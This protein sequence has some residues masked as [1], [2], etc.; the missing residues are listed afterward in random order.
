LGEWS[1]PTSAWIPGLI[2]RNRL[3]FTL[4]Q[5]L[6]LPQSYWITATVWREDDIVAVSHTDRQQ[7]DEDTVVLTDLPVTAVGASPTPPT[8]TDI[9]FPADGIILAGYD[10]PASAS[11]GDVVEAHFWWQTTARPSGDY[12]QF[13]HLIDRA[14][15]AQITQD[16]SP[17]GADRFPTSD[18]PV[19]MNE[20]A[21]WQISIP[22]DATPGTYQILTGLYSLPDLVRRE[23]VDGQGQPVPDNAVPLGTLTITAP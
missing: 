17:F 3:K 9:T 10:I 22:A 23:A 15:G 19:G 18:W 13:V 16:Q 6:D 8:A 20:V 2:V 4:P 12:Q 14:T 11:P 21:T 5:T 1:Y 7:V